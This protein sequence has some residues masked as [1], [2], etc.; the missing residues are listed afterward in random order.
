MA[1]LLSNGARWGSELE[2]QRRRGLVKLRRAGVGFPGI[3]PPDLGLEWAWVER[4]VPNSCDGAG[5]LP[6]NPDAID[7][8]LHVAGEFI[9]DR[10]G[11][12]NDR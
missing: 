12:S 10:L 5:W 9:Q 11:R 2:M 7:R 3:W 4:T 6:Y 8:L 1:T